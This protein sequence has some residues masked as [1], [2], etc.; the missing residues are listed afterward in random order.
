MGEDGWW[1][2]GGMESTVPKGKWREK[3]T[4]ESVL[5]ILSQYHHPQQ[6]LLLPHSDPSLSQKTVPSISLPASVAAQAIVESQRTGS[7]LSLGPSLAP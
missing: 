4:E 5:S 2:V 1:Q 7:G 6:L 3:V